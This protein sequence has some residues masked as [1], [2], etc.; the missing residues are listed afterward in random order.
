MDGSKYKIVIVES[1]FAGDVDANI[2]YAQKC[3][4]DCLS[5]QEAPYASHLLYTQPNVL[6]DDKPDE[7]YWGIEAGFAFKHMEGVHTVFY[8]DK[9]MSGGMQLAKDY[10]SKHEMTFEERYLYD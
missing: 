9:G 4:H 1:P 2:E 7:R 3:M 8:M 5:R 10:L 6:D